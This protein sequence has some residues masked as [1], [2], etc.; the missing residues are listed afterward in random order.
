[1]A[2]VCSPVVWW[3]FN[4]AH[5]ILPHQTYYEYKLSITMNQKEIKI[6]NPLAISGLQVST[7]NKN[8]FDPETAKILGLWENFH[9]TTLISQLTEK[10]P[11][12]YGVYS[13]YQSD[14][15]GDYS[16]TAGINA[17]NLNS[18]DQDLQ[19]VIIHP[20]RYL[21][22]EA[23]GEL[24]GAIIETWQYIWKYFSDTSSPKRKFTADFE[25]YIS[26]TEVDIHIAVED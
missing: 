18:P 21:V 1:M 16:V 24:P 14:E 22:F 23:R 3:T 5:A 10:D 26:E 2:M 7:N 17:K 19:E 6:E 20:G 25:K 12:I 15:N 11:F 8:E 13:D 4:Y 9:T